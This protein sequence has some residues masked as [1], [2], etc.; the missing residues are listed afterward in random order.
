MQMVKLLGAIGSISHGGQ[1]LIDSQTFSAI[2]SSVPD[3]VK[4]LRPRPDFGALAKYAHSRYPFLF[5]MPCCNLHAEKDPSLGRNAQQLAETPRGYLL[6]HADFWKVA[7]SSPLVSSRLRQGLPPANSLRV[8]EP[9]ESG[10]LLSKSNSMRHL[11]RKLSGKESGYKNSSSIVH[12]NE[13]SLDPNARLPFLLETRQ[14][15][16]TEGSFALAV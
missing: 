1:V 6:L 12:S 10:A 3:I 13:H 2:H 14:V 16:S 8:L 9:I 7:Q 4:L 11:L 15:C 5:I